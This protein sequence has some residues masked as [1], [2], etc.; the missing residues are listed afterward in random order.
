MEKPLVGWCV[1]GVCGCW[2]C[3]YGVRVERCE[4]DDERCCDASKGRRPVCWC[5]KDC[6]LRTKCGGNERKLSWHAMSF[7]FFFV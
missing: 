7:P 3:V 4:E 6:L 1:W 2:C 5:A